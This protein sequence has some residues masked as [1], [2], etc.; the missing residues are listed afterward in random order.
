MFKLVRFALTAL[1][2]LLISP[3]Q[4][5]ADRRVSRDNT[6]FDFKGQSGQIAIRNAYGKEASIK[7]KKIEEFDSQN[8]KVNFVNNFASQT[9]TWSAPVQTQFNGQNCTLINLNAILTPYYQVQGQNVYLNISTYIFNST[10]QVPYGNTTLTVPKDTVKFTISMSN[11]PFKNTTNTLRFGSEI[12]SEDND[13][14]KKKMNEF[15]KFKVRRDQEVDDDGKRAYNDRT[16]IVDNTGFYDMPSF[17]LINGVQTPVTVALWNDTD[18]NDKVGIVWTFPYFNNLVYDP[19]IGTGSP[20]YIAT[21]SST[22][23]S[24]VQSSIIVLLLAFTTFM[25]TF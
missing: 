11:W 2:F 8:K 25:V 17:A 6:D 24:V 19:V 21:S 9:Y 7:W 12:K 14:R 22:T 20:S 18:D 23:R 15:R 16:L 4:T 5:F 13:G 3:V 1:S 10:V